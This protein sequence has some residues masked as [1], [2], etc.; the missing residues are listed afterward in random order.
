MRVEEKRQTR[1]RGSGNRKSR[2]RSSL[3]KGPRLYTET[4]EGA[5]RLVIDYYD[6]IVPH[7]YYTCSR[8]D[9]PPTDDVIHEVI[10]VMEKKLARSMKYRGTR[11]CKAWVR[12]VT[13][14]ATLDYIFRRER[15]ESEEWWAV[16]DAEKSLQNQSSDARR[17]NF[18]E[19]WEVLTLGLSEAENE[20]LWLHDHMKKT[21]REVADTMRMKRREPVYRLLARAR[22]KARRNAHRHGLGPAA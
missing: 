19:T 21:A 6:V 9:R 14:R 10:L 16:C 3:D 8:W 2:R 20:V 1:R 12:R 4:S 15:S 11:P 5:T 18:L 7:I 22:Q 13:Y 17:R